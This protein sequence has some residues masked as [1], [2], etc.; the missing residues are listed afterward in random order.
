MEAEIRRPMGCQIGAQNQVRQPGAGLSWYLEDRI[1]AV[2][3]DPGVFG[4]GLS[5][6]EQQHRCLFGDNYLIPP[7]SLEL[8]QFCL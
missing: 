7:S 5:Q 3:C 8:N 2:H 6:Q 1:D 4:P